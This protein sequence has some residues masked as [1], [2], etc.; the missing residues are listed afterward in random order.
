MKVSVIV[1]VYNVEEY[2]EQCILSL[3]N[4]KFQD[5]EIIVV[6]DGSKDNSIEKIQYL[7]NK[8]ENIRLINQ[9]NAG[10]SAAR[11]TGLKN[12]KGKYIS[13]VDS[14]DWVESNFLKNLYVAAEENDADIVCAGYKKVYENTDK[15]D[16]VMVR[17]AELIET[18][19]ISGEEA[20]LYQYEHSE[21]RM[22]VWDDLY[23]REFLFEN[24]LLFEEG[25]L[26]EDEM[27]TPLALLKANRVKFIDDI[28]YCYRQRDNSIMNSLKNEKHAKSLLKAS[29]SLLKYTNLTEDK[30]LKMYLARNSRV[31]YTSCLKID[32]NRRLAKKDRDKIWVN[33]EKNRTLKDFLVLK[34]PILF[35]SVYN[36]KTTTEK[37]L[38]HAKK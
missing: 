33:L 38:T 30:S 1:P 14:D 15:K 29:E 35:S 13:F 10:L 17:S 6:N 31:I 18:Q 5:F 24:D 4:Q 27:F 22:E 37:V 11:N 32:A 9:K 20:L 8:Y 16:E 2:I 25:Y 12:S 19:I 3:L 7:I 36:I 23:R 26:H 34:L 28:S 21:Y